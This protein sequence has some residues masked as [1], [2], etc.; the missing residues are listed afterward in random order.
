[1]CV[2]EFTFVCMYASA[3]T[4]TS[5]C[6][7]VCVYERERKRESER[8]RKLGGEVGR[9]KEGGE[10]RRDSNVHLRIHV[11]VCTIMQVYVHAQNES[12]YL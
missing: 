10:Y 9:E 7:F 2:C 12:T 5:V 4:C 11:H 6:V 3:C 1:M 8:E